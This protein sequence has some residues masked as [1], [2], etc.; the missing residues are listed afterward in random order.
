MK[1]KINLKK[2]GIMQALTR[3]QCRVRHALLQNRC[4]KIA[5]GKKCERYGKRAIKEI[6]HN[7]KV[8]YKYCNTFNPRVAIGPFKVKRNYHQR[9][10]NHGEHTTR[11][12]LVCVSQTRQTK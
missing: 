11:S 2:I 3:S 12:V 4:L 6:R 9:G 7:N 5:K 8:L 1:D 10:K